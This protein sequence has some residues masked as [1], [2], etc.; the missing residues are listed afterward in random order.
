M[1]TF[2][3]LD[4]LIEQIGYLLENFD[5][6]VHNDEG[7]RDAVDRA[8]AALEDLEGAVSDLVP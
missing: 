5:Y 3:E 2:P 8:T 6:D 7:N 1:D 4:R